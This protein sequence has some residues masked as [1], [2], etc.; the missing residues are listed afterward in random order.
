M[1]PNLQLTVLLTIVFL[2]IPFVSP[3]LGANGSG[4]IS[5]SIY[6]DNGSTN[7]LV[8]GYVDNPEGLPFLNASGQI[9]EEDTGMLYDVTD[10]LIKPD[11]KSWCLKFPLKGYYDEYHVVFYIPGMVELKEMDCSEGLEF[12]ASSYNNSLIINVQG[13]DVSN[14]EVAISYQEPEKD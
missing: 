1:T 5:L 12:L 9:Y 11:G 3:A 7:A 13:F 10:S 14:P 4:Q 8:V 6:V 2:A